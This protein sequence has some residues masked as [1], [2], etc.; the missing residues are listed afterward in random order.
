MIKLSKK[1]KK[2]K[3]KKRYN[4]FL[5]WWNILENE[6]SKKLKI[7]KEKCKKKDKVNK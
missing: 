5:K 1:I 2:G 6:K 3:S 7:E 4:I